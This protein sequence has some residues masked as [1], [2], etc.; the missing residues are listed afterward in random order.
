MDY[1]EC[2]A[3]LTAKRLA[4]SCCLISKMWLIKDEGRTHTA[5]DDIDVP[6]PTP[7]PTTGDTL[8]YGLSMPIDGSFTHD[9]F[10]KLFDMAKLSETWIFLDVGAPVTAPMATVVTLVTWLITTGMRVKVFQVV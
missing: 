3:P 1:L 10:N 6:N 9:S 8:A 2:H 5:P 7:S 4:D